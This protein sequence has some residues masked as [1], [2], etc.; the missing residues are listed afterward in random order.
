MRISD[1]SSDVCSSDL[2]SLAIVAGA[3]AGAVEQIDQFGRRDGRGC[4]QENISLLKAP[5]EAIV[6]FDGDR[7]R[8]MKRFRGGARN[9]QHEI[10]SLDRAPVDT[11]KGRP[12]EHKRPAP[13]VA[14]DTEIRDPGTPVQPANAQDR[15]P[16]V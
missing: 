2:I 16:S 12:T 1:W 15:K 4:R 7:R 6:I 13:L 8:Y 10:Q 11:G 3:K 14:H 5:E 9:R